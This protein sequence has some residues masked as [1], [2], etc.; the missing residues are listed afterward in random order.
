MKKKCLAMLMCLLSAALVLTSCTGGATKN[1]KFGTGGTTGTYYPYGGAIAKVWNEKLTSPKVNVTVESTGASAVNIRNV[2]KK[3]NDLALVQNDVMK[4]AT[5]GTMSFTA[6]GKITSF[7]TIASLYD[8][9]CQIIVS[10]DSPIQTVADLKGKIVSVGDAG[11]GVEAN[12]QQILEAYGLSFSDIKQQNLSFGDSA[13]AIKD[14]KI[15]AFFCTAGTPTTAIVELA[16][17]KAVRVL[18]IDDAKAQELIKKY[19][20]YATYTIPKDTYKGMTADVPTI[21]VKAT[22]ICRKDLDNDLVYKLT[23]ALFDYKGDIAQAHAKGQFLTIE[24]AVKGISVPLHPGAEKYF[25][26][27][28]ALK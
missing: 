13:T 14:Q 6:D 12:A 8:E 11:S 23:K 16:T 7:S 26:E 17:T 15:D 4:Y 20:Y 10:A 9:V 2:N 24:D 28:G 25:K 22:L 5:E 27:V 1:L 3:E 18:P 19:P 21:V